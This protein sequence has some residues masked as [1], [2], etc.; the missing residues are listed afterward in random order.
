MRSN[1][2]HR[3]AQTVRCQDLFV[4]VFCAWPIAGKPVLLLMVASIVRQRFALLILH[5]EAIA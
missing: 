3:I 2:D 5:R 1:R 4:G